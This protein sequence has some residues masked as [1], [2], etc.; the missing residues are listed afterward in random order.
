MS[1]LIKYL[2]NNKS[3]KITCPKCGDLISPS[4]ANLF[5]VREKYPPKIQAILKRI[6]NN[7]NKLKIKLEAKIYKIKEQII[8]QKKEEKLLI[9]KI[10][11]KPKKIK[12]ITK[13]INI[14]QIVEEILPASKFFTY[15][16]RDCRA[17]Y[18]P[19]DYISFNGLSKKKNVQSISILEIKSGSARLQQNQ[20]E[21]KQHIEAGNIQYMEY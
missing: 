3:L 21:I 12:T 4:Q 6:M 18:K 20:K 16:V 15:D 1:D 7:Q 9:T 10:K 5:D 13:H 8:A 14:G 19:I 11:N 2:K 17:L